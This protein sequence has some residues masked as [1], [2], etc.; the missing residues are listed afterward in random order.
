MEEQ[1]PKE[2][3][4]DDEEDEDSDPGSLELPDDSNSNA[5]AAPPPA[6]VK[7]PATAPV[8]LPKKLPP[9]TTKP[10][11]TVAQIQQHSPS[12]QG[13]SKEKADS[14][15]SPPVQTAPQKTIA[16][17]PP[18]KTAAQEDK[19]AALP[20]C[21]W[22][23]AA[24][25]MDEATG[26]AKLRVFCGVWNL[27]GKSPPEDISEWILR[28][29]APHVYVI[30]TCE[31]EHS[32]ERSL[33]WSSKAR[34]EQR[35]TKYLGA[36]YQMFGSHNMSAIHIMV[37]VHK[38]I[39]KYCWNQKTTQVATGF[40]NLVGNKGGTLVSFNVGHSTLLFINAHLPAGEK[41][42]EDRTQSL[43]RILFDANIKQDKEK[44]DKGLHEEH[45]HVFFMGDLN[46][47]VA[48]KY[49]QV[50]EWLDNGEIETCRSHDQLSP[51]LGGKAEDAGL[52]SCFQEAA[53]TFAPTYK[54]DP[55][56][57]QYD[58]SKKKRTPSWTDRILWKR[59]RGIRALEYNCVTALK[60]SDHRPIFGRFE[61]DVDVSAWEGPPRA[62][63]KKTDAGSAVCTVQ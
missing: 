7:A 27:H 17:D 29:K 56:T 51:L 4:E 16:Q 13:E 33:I 34:W 61:V 23:S 46:P 38:H 55:G 14:F 19:P 10:A 21:E 60:S 25:A 11:S 41:N 18:Q 31:C 20:G 28:D 59:D 32:I 50:L 2:E 12:P 58:T 5:A 52:W 37:F 26:W 53:I 49:A 15:K 44:K 43:R 6:A 24:P 42:M 47:R 1:L 57:D 63:A 3:D 30:G 45:D 9:L 35:V 62:A 48:A 40:A 8:P 39:W 54:F 36:D 22:E